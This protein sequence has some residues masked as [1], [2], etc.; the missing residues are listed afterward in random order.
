[1]DEEKLKRSLHLVV[2]NHLYKTGFKFSHFLPGKMA[3]IRSR[4]R[5]KSI[6]MQFGVETSMNYLKRSGSK[7]RV[8]IK[9]DRFIDPYKMKERMSELL[10]ERYT[11]EEL[12]EINGNKT[13]IFVKYGLEKEGSGYISVNKVVRIFCKTPLRNKI[14]VY[15]EEI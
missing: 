3:T 2:K 12:A 10:L 8:L 7:S 15:E 4:L 5:G 6:D 11:H 9:K 1:M 14:F 13:S